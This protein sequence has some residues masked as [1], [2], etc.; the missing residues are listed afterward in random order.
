[1]KIYLV[2]IFVILFACTESKLMNPDNKNFEQKIE[3]LANLNSYKVYKIDSINN[4]YL[5]YAKKKDSLYKIVSKK[6]WDV[7]CNLIKANEEYEFMLHSQSFNPA[8]G[9]LEILPEN[10]LLVNCFY[11]DDSTKICLERD[12]IN[13]L[14]YGDNIRGLCFKKIDK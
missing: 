5:I 1:M 9:N 11:Y 2:L 8:T 13:D 14:F 4:F 6:E 10:S 12:S 7:D 3:D